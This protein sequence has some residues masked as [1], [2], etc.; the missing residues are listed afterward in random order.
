MHLEES[1]LC[2]SAR[3]PVMAPVGQTL[4]QRWQPVHLLGDDAVLDQFPADGRR[5]VTSLIMCS[6]YSARK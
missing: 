6:R 4:T 1:R 3:G 5:A 2:G